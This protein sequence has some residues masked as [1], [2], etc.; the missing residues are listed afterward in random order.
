MWL[1]G[2]SLQE[3][4]ATQQTILRDKRQKKR[5]R[6]WEEKERELEEK[7]REIVHAVALENKKIEAAL[8]AKAVS[9]AAPLLPCDILPKLPSYLE[10]EDIT[11]YFARFERVAAL[12]KIPDDDCAIQLGSLL[13][14]KLTEIYATLSEDIQ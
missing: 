13:T 2:D 6:E 1:E 11:T 3:F 7:E 10:G 9:P 8:Q 12:L 5:D 14:G 4:V